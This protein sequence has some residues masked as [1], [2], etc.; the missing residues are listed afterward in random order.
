MTVDPDLPTLSREKLEM[1]VNS[2]A[3]RQQLSDPTIQ[4]MLRNI[5]QTLQQEEDAKKNQLEATGSEVTRLKL[6]QLN[7]SSGTKAADLMTKMREN[8]P[9]FAK[10]TSTIMDLVQ[11][12][13]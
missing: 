1:L 2:T 11:E 5:E 6:Q 13:P 10:L 12:S 4:E 9:A 7:W 3:L 8:D